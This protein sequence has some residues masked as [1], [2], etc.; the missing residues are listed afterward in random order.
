MRIVA[1]PQNNAVLIYAT[2]DEQD[3]V[4]AMLRKIDILPLQV[5]I[6]ATIAEVTLNDALQY[7]IEYFF[8]AGV[9]GLL[10]NNGTRQFGTYNGF[11]LTG[12]SGQ[13]VALHALQDVTQVR[14][15]SAPQLTVMDNQAAHLQVGQLVPI[16]TQQS[17]S[18]L[19]SSAPI[20]NSVSYQPTG[21][22]LQVTPH[23]NS[24]GMVALDISQEVSSV[25]AQATGT[26]N[27]GSPTFQER[28]VQSRVAV[29]DGQTVGLA[30]LIQDQ[31]SRDNSGIP[32]LKDIPLLGF[33]AGTQSN[34]RNRTELLVL[35]TPR[36]IHDQ[37]DARAL[38]EDLREGLRNAAITPE[39]LQHLPAS[40]FADP[41]ASLRS[42][43][44]RS[45]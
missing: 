12:P 18:T 26:Q 1:N 34:Q 14:V 22:I 21:V 28:Q 19:S 40:G 6:D 27:T 20:V 9:N 41:Q 33:L 16:L 44:E 35:I 38:T 30:G 4:D 7:G 23:I 15:L 32:Y 11:T 31:D 5:R 17:Q 29:Q 45:R 3:T 10:S 37:R 24:G 42:H 2:R 8:A 13:S 25:A 39:I 43:L 36:V